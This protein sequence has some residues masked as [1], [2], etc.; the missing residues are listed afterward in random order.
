MT[1]RR[2]AS[3]VVVAVTLAM[4][5]SCS[6]AKAREQHP[7]SPVSQSSGATTDACVAPAGLALQ[8]QDRSDHQVPWRRNG[9]AKVVIN[10]ET[11]NVPPDWVA[12]MQKG[13]AAWN[14]S[15]C[16]DTKLVNTCQPK[17]NC[18]TVRVARESVVGADGN[19][20]AVESGGLPLSYRLSHPYDAPRQ[21]LQFT[22]WDML[23]ALHT[24][25]RNTYS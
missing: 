17:T 6:F 12:E 4:L 2:F 5:A 18:V 20:D 9:A 21:M 13:V 19:F 10:F 22:K 23:S 1:C 7:A 14:K 25:R 8:D 16:L 15:P 24:G 3:A 11:K